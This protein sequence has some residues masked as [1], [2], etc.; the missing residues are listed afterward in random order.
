MR[1]T[2]RFRCCRAP[3][4]AALL[5]AVWALA[6]MPLGAVLVLTI[7][8]NTVV[9]ATPAAA[10]YDAGF[11]EKLTANTLTVEADINWKVT[12][13]G[14][15]TSWSCTGTGCWGAKPRGDVQWRLAAGSYTALTGVAATVTTGSTTSPPSTVDVVVDYRIMISW[16]TDTPG[17][18]SYDFLTYELTAL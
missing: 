13:L 17:V 12:V 4:G 16:T 8:S 3:V 11:V 6:P 18:Y 1:R 15:S 5:L 14:T 2:D 10:D 9:I 7:D